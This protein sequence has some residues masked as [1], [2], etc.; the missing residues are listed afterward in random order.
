MVSVIHTDSDTTARVV[1]D[2]P[3]LCV[4]SIIRGEGNGEFT[5][6]VNNKVG[7][8]VLVTEGMSAND[9]GLSPSG[10]ISWDVLDDDGLSEDG[11]IENVTDGSIG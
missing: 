9:D 6:S 8:S 2:F 5:S 7:G 3:L 11:T 1:E 10:N 4:S